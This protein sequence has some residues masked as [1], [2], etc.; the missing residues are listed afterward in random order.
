MKLIIGLGNPEEQYANTRHNLG[1]E[2]LDQFR[3]KKDLG[4]WSMEEKLR[5]EIIKTPDLVL[6]RPQTYMN[7]SGQGV[8][9]VANFYKISP[10]DII[11]CYDEL[12]LPLGQIKV[13]L[14][15][16]AAGHHGVESVISSLGTDRF[17]RLRL[18]IGNN[19]AFL[20]ERKKASLNVEHFVLEP[21]PQQDRPKVKAMLKSALKALDLYLEQGLEKAQT[22]FN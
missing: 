12:D 8:A 13:R 3:R 5:S 15:G 22:Q 18:G 20:A 9:A 19:L 17:V 7:N 21:F 1:F 14:G 6:A 10:E 11:V 4:E 16:A 2:L